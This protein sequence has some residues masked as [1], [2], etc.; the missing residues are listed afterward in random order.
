MESDSK[1]PPIYDFQKEKV[2]FESDAIMYDKVRW[3]T[4]RDL[5]LKRK[6]QVQLPSYAK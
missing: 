1:R 5:I 4:F 3:P 2:Q 6:T